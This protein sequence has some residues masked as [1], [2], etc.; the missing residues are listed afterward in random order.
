MIQ[1][2]EE[3]ATKA[4]TA[5]EVD[6]ARTGM[7]KNID[8]T[9]S[10]SERVGLELSEWMAMGDWRL[11]FLNRDRIKKVTPAD[12]QRVAAAYLKPANRTVGCSCP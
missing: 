3:F 1:T 4:P 10:S 8:L 9:L 12:V 5:E 11:F 2:V 7:L 6:R